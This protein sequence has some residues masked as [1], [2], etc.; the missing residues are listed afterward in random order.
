M[1]FSNFSREIFERDFHHQQPMVLTGLVP[2]WPASTEWT[3]EQLTD[4]Q[5]VWMGK[6]AAPVGF[7][8]SQDEKRGM[9]GFVI[10]NRKKHRTCFMLSSSG[11]ISISDLW[12]G[13]KVWPL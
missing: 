7:W 11:N 4:P 3:W 6:N 1:D 5:G 2:T 12:D 9:G 10:Q 8:C 13:R